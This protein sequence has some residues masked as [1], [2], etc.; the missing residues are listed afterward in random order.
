MSEG[1]A[2]KPEV[3]KVPKT[4][5]GDSIRG[6]PE[7]LKYFEVRLLHPAKMWD[8]AERQPGRPVPD[9]PNEKMMR[10][11]CLHCK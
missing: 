11:R 4:K 5:K 9:H 8:R 2:A 1:P 6:D 10:Y 7:V 3:T